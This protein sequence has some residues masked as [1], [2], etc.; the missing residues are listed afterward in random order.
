MTTRHT[1]GPW[2]IDYTPI[3][4]R[5]EGDTS[6]WSTCTLPGTVRRAEHQP[7]STVALL[8][9]HSEEADARLIAAAPNMLACLKAIVSEWDEANAH[10][11]HRT[12]ITPDSNGIEWA[13]E[14]I[15]AAEGDE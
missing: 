13:R 8:P 6:G 5:I 4:I 15:S 1:P 2:E 9:G 14:A 10:E 12:G 11:T 3:Q 7:H